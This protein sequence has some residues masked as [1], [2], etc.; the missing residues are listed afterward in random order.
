MAEVPPLVV[1]VTSTVPALSAGA[2]TLNEVAESAVMIPG[3]EPKLTVVARFKLVPVKVTMLPPLIEPLLG[4]TAATVGTI[5][6]SAALIEV[7][8]DAAVTL[9]AFAADWVL[10]R[11]YH[12]V[13]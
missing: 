11:L 4:V 5:S 3:I 1:T 2:I 9:T 12:W 13:A 8:V 10:A 7:A 6:P